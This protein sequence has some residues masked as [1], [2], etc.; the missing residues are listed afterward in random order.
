MKA[1]TLFITSVLFFLSCNC[2]KATSM[3]SEKQTETT[4]LQE[5]PK[6]IYESSSRGFYK[7]V[8]IE[9]NKITIVSSR[10]E[11]GVSKDL[12]VTEVEAI[13]N[14]LDVLD[15]NKIPSLKAPSEKR[16]S[17]AAPI[18][19]LEIIKEDQSFKTVDF[20]GGYPP[21]YIADLV[22]K[23]LKIAEKVQ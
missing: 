22:N 18:T 7:L 19:N 15:L 21:E 11:A 3:T 23:I 5:L 17:D 20:D 2:K 16:F 8:A 9:K 6:L 4:T 14:H 1:V 13:K 10:G 12:S